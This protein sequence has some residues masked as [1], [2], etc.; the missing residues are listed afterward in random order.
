MLIESC[1][2]DIEVSTQSADHVEYEVIA[3]LDVD[4]SPVLPY[5]NATLSRAI[6]LPDKPALSWR[7]G[8]CNIGFWP[9]RIA[10]D[11]L[12]SREEV[13]QMVE[14]LVNLVNETWERRDQL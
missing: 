9:N 2:L 1:D 3:H 13:E 4:I 11:H 14:R 12:H 5:L 6:Y 10:I 8:E 7:R